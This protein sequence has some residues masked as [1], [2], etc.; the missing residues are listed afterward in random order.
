METLDIGAVKAFVLAAELQ[1]FTRAAD[2]LGITQSAVSLKLRRLEEQL[3]RRL[4]ERTPRQVRL[5]AE[6][7]AFIG[8]ARDLVSTHDLAVS[9]FETEP[10]RLVVGI[11]HQLIGGELPSLLG[12]LRDH[13]PGL[14]IEMRIGGTRELM[15]AYDQGQLDAALVLRP[16]D[17][18][19]QGRAAFTEAFSWFAATGWKAPAGKPL[20]LA[21][22]GES[23]G[24]RGAA[25]RALDQAG[26]AWDEVFVGKGAAL[27]GAAAAGGLAVAVLAKRAAPQGTMDVGGVLSLP[28]IPS[29]EVMLYSALTDRRSREALRVLTL[30]FR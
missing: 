25:V 2:A 17:R 21:T 19:K 4:L 20:P 1:S 5:S 16:E 10:R 9:A 27:L 3:G 29:Q 6:G 22:Q 11:S 24:I 13:D 28:P 7:L 14:R 30:A 23:C 18:R 8:A 15:Q 12:N 26:I